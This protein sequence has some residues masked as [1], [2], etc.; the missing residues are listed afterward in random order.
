MQIRLFGEFQ[1][2]S[3]GTITPA[4]QQPRLQA[5]LAYLVLHRDVPQSRR[6]LAFTFWP[7]TSE[8]QARNNLRQLLFQLRRTCPEAEQYLHTDSLSVWWHCDDMLQLDVAE[9]EAAITRADESFRQAAPQR[10]RAALEQALHRYTGDLLPDCYDDWIAPIRE[11]LQHCYLQA[12]DQQIALLEATRE[13]SAALVYAQRRLLADPLDETACL[14]LM[15]LHTLNHNRAAALRT[16]RQYADTLDTELGLE[17]GEQI[18]SMYAQLQR[19]DTDERLAL[20]N[21]ADA[22]APLIGRHAEWQQLQAL[23]QHTMQGAAHLM[24]IGGE[25][26]IGKTRLADEFLAWAGRQGITTAQTRAYAA[27]GRL[28]YAA[29][30]EWLRSPVFFSAI[31]KLDGVWLSEIARVVPEVLITR[32]ELTPPGPLTEHWQRQ[33]FYQALV[34]G[35]L[36][37]N[38]PLVLQFDDLQWCDTETLEWLHFLLRSKPEVRL[39]MIGT[40]RIEERH[41]NPALT[42]LFHALRST[43]QLIEITLAPLDAAETMQVAAHVLGHELGIDAAT[44]LFRET[45]GNPLF[46]VEMAQASPA[47][48]AVGRMSS[49]ESS[50]QVLLPPRMYAVIAARL[51]QLSPDA[52]ELLGL[53][54][55][56]GR[57]FTVDVLVHASGRMLDALAAPLDELWQR[58]I[59]REHGRHAYDFSHDKLR[60][61][62]YREL[63]PV[64]RRTCHRRV[65]QALEALAAADLDPISAQ[66]AAHYEQAGLINES[67]ESY[68]R[69]A[70]AAQRIFA[71]AEAAQLLRRGLALLP[72]IAGQR[73]RD[74][75]ELALQTALGASLVALKGYG[76]A[77]VMETYRRAH[78]LGA[79]LG[80]PPSPP[81]LRGLALTHIVQA[82]SARALQL[83]EQIFELACRSNDPVLLV[84][85]QY[86]MGVS[87]LW[88]G[89]FIPSQEHLRAALAQYQTQQTATHLALYAQDLRIVCLIRSA[90]NLWIL[91]Y[92]EQAQRARTEA[93]ALAYALEHPFTLTYAAYYATHLAAITR[94]LPDVI[95]GAADTITLCR[96]HQVRYWSALATICQGWALGVQGSTDEGIRQIKA[97]IAIRNGDGTWVSEPF[98]LALLAEVYLRAGDLMQALESVDEGLRVATARGEHWYTADLHRLRGDLLVLQGQEA[99]GAQAFQQA[100]LVART[101]H[102]RAF[103]LRAA[104]SL[105][106]LE[107]RH[108][109]YTDAYHLLA[110][111]YAWFTE[112]F[113]TPDLT[114]ARLL[115]DELSIAALELTPG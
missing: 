95:T 60:D 96:E 39:L 1:L 22:A 17:P 90:E 84:E 89:R 12:L 88:Q 68:Q 30:T 11:R 81:V 25:A 24:V 70:R 106:R 66:L 2:I 47:M 56:I 103:E 85:G 43:A 8:T 104:I 46:V 19:M 15:R 42:R 44:R 13:Y 87:L 52:T 40:L 110:P 108:G 27:E 114:T 58:R 99:L 94:T 75:R 62:A 35:I 76:A 64:Q 55:T 36:A 61:V 109:R 45:E 92:P 51:S 93:L 115:L 65:A 78:H 33:R 107:Q 53:A 4:M 59:I 69:A 5:L 9:F 50:S 80:Q 67:L 105:A 37:F 31:Q 7:D 54:A 63:S 82:E 112:G 26:G 77:D 111:L 38:M 97:G 6:R 10:A 49:N 57:A 71:H 20:V 32:P 14:R 83:G 16:Y 29:I 73:E 98:Y 86:V 113:E 100:L 72:S 74:L 3:A 23:W 48:Q 18:Q 91:G 34:H 102:A 79:Q 21:R 101:Q 41:T 28:P